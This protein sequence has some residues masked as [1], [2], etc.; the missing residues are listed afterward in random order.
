MLTTVRRPTLN[1]AIS[2]EIPAS[3]RAGIA[4]TK[5]TEWERLEKKK[6]MAMIQNADEARACLSV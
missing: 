5:T 3:V 2:V 1:A 6:V 4:C